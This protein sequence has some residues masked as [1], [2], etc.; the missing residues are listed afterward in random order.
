MK[1]LYHPLILICSGTIEVV[2][3]WGDKYRYPEKYEI[4]S[5]SEV[6]GVIEREFVPW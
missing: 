2:T 4:L 6:K 5:D 1:V 3:S